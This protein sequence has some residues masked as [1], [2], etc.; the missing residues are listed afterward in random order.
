M[1]ELSLDGVLENGLPK[2]CF[3]SFR[4]GDIQK[5]SRLA[6]GRN[7]RFPAG[8][9]D[10]DDAKRYARIEVFQRIGSCS[11]DVNPLN[12]GQRELD[13]SCAEAGFGTLRLKVGVGQTRTL[14]DS[15]TGP[16]KPH[17]ALAN[18]VQSK[19][20]GARNYLN[21][22]GIEAQLSQAMQSLLREKPEN[23]AEYLASKLCSSSNVTKLQPLANAPQLG[24]LDGGLRTPL[25]PVGP[26]PGA[27]ARP[28]HRLEPLGAQQQQQQQQQQQSP[29]PQEQPKAQ[30]AG[31]QQAQ[32]V[33]RPGATAAASSAVASKPSDV[34]PHRG[35]GSEHQPS[36]FL[37]VAEHFKV[38]PK[39]MQTAL[40]T[41][42]PPVAAKKYSSGT[43]GFPVVGADHLA[44]LYAA[45]PRRMPQ[46]ARKAATSSAAQLAGLDCKTM[47]P[48]Y[49]KFPAFAVRQK[50]GPSR[51]SSV[52]S[53]TLH[54][55]YTKFPAYVARQKSGMP[56]FA[57]V[58]QNSLRIVYNKFPAYVDAVAKGGK[59]GP[60]ERFPSVGQAMMA[61]IYD[62]FPT[63]TRW[64]DAQVRSWTRPGEG[65]ALPGS[66]PSSS[67]RQASAT[68]FRPPSHRLPSVA[69]WH[70]RRVSVNKMDAPGPSRKT[71]FK[72]SVGS[73]LT[74]RLP[75]DIAKTND[76]SVAAR[77]AV[78]N[79]VATAAAAERNCWWIGKSSVCT[80]MLK[81]Q[82]PKG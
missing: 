68:T 34:R 22:H 74:R 29:V 14:G 69:T 58:S 41:R 5:I 32:L 82:K 67:S 76:V 55:L 26:P 73:W 52:D 57:S 16:A 46:L 47:Q 66:S 36:W 48:L 80:W 38:V 77:P 21:K 64:Q 44:K 79:R 28:P 35:F 3:I 63:K 45:F 13:V 11:V 70:S 18:E 20:E 9:V 51:Y 15:D 24:A 40:L 65:G 42:F 78:D 72:P 56:Q 7:F 61:R 54:K 2:E 62:K 81:P 8:A 12:R 71:F 33:A 50:S 31:P 75:K 4:L 6:T 27:H 60:S 39:D 49:A 10:L 1:V 59:R 25:A 37:Y 43:V 23:P 19:K 30:Q 53:A 17:K